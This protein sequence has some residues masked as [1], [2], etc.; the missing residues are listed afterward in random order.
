M[1]KIGVHGAMIFHMFMYFSRMMPSYGAR[2][3]SDSFA[4][5][6]RYS[7]IFVS[8]IL[9]HNSH[10]LERIPIIFTLSSRSLLDFSARRISLFFSAFCICI[11][12]L[13]IPISWVLFEPLLFTRSGVTEVFHPLNAHSIPA[14]SDLNLLNK[15]FHPSLSS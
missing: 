13:S 6:A 5:C 7:F 2:I 1:R 14:V 10:F 3:I 12:M 4:S 11:F 8:V 9:V 15:V